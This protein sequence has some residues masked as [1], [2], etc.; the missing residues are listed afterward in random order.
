MNERIEFVRAYI[1]VQCTAPDGTTGD[2]LFRKNDKGE[3]ELISP[4]FADLSPLH[5]WLEM[6]GWEQESFDSLHPVGVFRRDPDY[7]YHNSNELQCERIFRT[8]GGIVKLDHGVPGDGT[9]WR[10]ADWTGKKFEH[11]TGWAY[12]ENTI[13]PCDLIDRLPDDWDKK[14][15][16]KT[17]G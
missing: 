3:R 14:Q 5:D 12:Y 2:F 7:W 4:V 13:E 6:N 11:D 17:A 8:D 15:P 10:V 16:R 9:R 1:A